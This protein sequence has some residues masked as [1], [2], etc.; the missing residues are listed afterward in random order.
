VNSPL[1]AQRLA[2]LVDVQNIYYPAKSLGDKVNFLSLIKRFGSRQLVRAIA[3]VVEAPDVDVSPFV[4]ALRNIGF[5]VR[6]KAVRVFEDGTRK[7]DI[8]LMLALD[9][10]SLAD[11]VDAVCL[12][13]GDGEYVD[14]VHLLRGRGI[15]V[16]VM[17]F[18]SNTSAE[19]L[20]VCDE[21][22]PMNEEF[23]LGYG[24]PPLREERAPERPERGRTFGNDRALRPLGYRERGGDGRGGDGRD[25]RLGIGRRDDYY[26]GRPVLRHERTLK[27]DRA[28]GDEHVLRD[29]RLGRDDRILRERRGRFS[30]EGVE[31]PEPEETGEPVDE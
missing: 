22:F 3:Y 1:S 8:H 21:H 6:T 16:E 28:P 7:G 17:S 27:D 15:K 5:E 19:L 13:T 26:S 4:G 24:G 14:L 31:V 23:L 2:L 11:R 20:R 30:S 10:M 12:V 29:E 18:R 9:A 25:A